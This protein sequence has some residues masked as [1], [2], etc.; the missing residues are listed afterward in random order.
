MTDELRK[1]VISQLP[2]IA[3]SCD[4]LANW[5]CISPDRTMGE[6]MEWMNQDGHELDNIFLRLA[7][8]VLQIK[9]IIHHVVGSHSV[10]I[11]PQV[12]FGDKTIYLL[13]FEEIHFSNQGHYQSIVPVE[14]LPMF[15]V[16]Q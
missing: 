4:E 1:Y 5:N 3:M 6:W 14:N 15:G 11:E 13:Y 9:I 10:A 2:K 16:N 7:A 8:E 12:V